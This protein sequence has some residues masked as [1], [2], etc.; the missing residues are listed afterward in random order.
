M[1][2]IMLRQWLTAPNFLPIRLYANN[3]LPPLPPSPISPTSPSLFRKVSPSIS[4]NALL[5]ASVVPSEGP[6]SIHVRKTVDK[7]HDL[8]SQYDLYHAQAVADGT[9]LPTDSTVFNKDGKQK[10]SGYDV[11]ALDFRDHW[12]QEHPELADCQPLLKN[13]WDLPVSEELLHSRRMRISTAAQEDW[14]AMDN[15]AKALFNVRADVLNQPPV[16]T[17]EQLINSS[18]FSW[19]EL[20]QAHSWFNSKECR[21]Q[22][23]AQRMQLSSLETE[24]YGV[25]LMAKNAECSVVDSF[26]PELDEPVSGRPERPDT[27]TNT[28]A[29]KA[30]GL[31]DDIDNLNQVLKQRREPNK[32]AKNEVSSV[33]MGSDSQPEIMKTK[34]LQQG[35]RTSLSI[36][37]L[38]W[39]SMSSLDQAGVKKGMKL[40][41]KKSVS[42]SI[43]REMGLSPKSNDDSA[44]SPTK[45]DEEK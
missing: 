26:N 23:R 31:Q 44:L 29:K 14:A 43:Q 4:R 17:V 27:A 6:H 12:N 35:R 13:E 5:P 38:Q 9:K 20:N 22:F 8:M 19:D 33:F 37:D 39:K 24:L 30:S 18:N 16:P 41:R 28:E 32:S 15:E 34:K 3:R 11:F 25:R 45:Q 10:V 36:T 21:D 42:M 1:T 7:E 2:C 40:R